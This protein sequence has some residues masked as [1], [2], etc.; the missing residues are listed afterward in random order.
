MHNTQ[1]G[2]ISFKK[3]LQMQDITAWLKQINLYANVQTCIAK[4]ALNANFQLAILDCS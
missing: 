3:D 2:Y 4:L 1:A